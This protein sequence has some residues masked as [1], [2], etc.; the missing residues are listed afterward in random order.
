MFRAVSNVT[1]GVA[2]TDIRLGRLIPVAL[3]IVLLVAGMAPAQEGRRSRAAIT[4]GL[5]LMASKRL[6]GARE[7]V[8][9]AEW[10]AALDALESL[11]TDF[12]DALVEI[13]PDRFV[14]VHDV[15]LAIIASM[16]RDGLAIYRGRVDGTV[17]FL[18]RE[19]RRRD[20]P[21]A[22]SQLLRKYHPSSYGDDALEWLAEDAWT[23]GE[24]DQARMYWTQLVP[25]NHSAPPPQPLVLRFPD[26]SQPLPS[27]LARLVLCSLLQRDFAAAESELTAFRELYPDAEGALAGRD[28]RLCEILEGVLF[29]AR[30]WPDHVTEIGCKTFACRPDRNSV[31][32]P[33]PV[34]LQPLWQTSL[35]RSQLRLIDVGRP[36]SISQL[37][38]ETFPV[39]DNG[40]VLIQDDSGIRALNLSDGRPAWPTGRPDDR[41]QVYQATDNSSVEL[42]VLGIP[43]YSGTVSAGRFFA[44]IGAPVSAVASGSLR[45]IDD[46]LISL[47]LESGEGRLDWEVGTEDL[48][49]QEGWR[50]TGAPLA[51]DERLYVTIRRTAV[52]V[53]LA[54]A[55]IDA[56]TG[57]LLWQQPVAIDL[58]TPPDAY[59][60]IEHEL[61]S[62]GAGAVYFATQAGLL[63]SLN[64]DSGQMNWVATYPSYP[65]SPAEL[66]HP[67]HAGLLPPVFDRGT[68][69]LAPRDASHVMA[70][71]AAT[72][73]L[74]WRTPKPG[75]INALLG[76]A[77]N[78]LV[79]GGDRLWRISADSG[80]V[81]A[82]FGYDDPAGFGFGRGAIAGRSIFWTTREELFEV[83]IASGAALR[84]IPLELLRQST[85]GNLVI[86]DG[87]LLI[88]EPGRLS[89][90]STR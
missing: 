28:G 52:Q 16:P 54:I 6:E 72:G 76:I 38:L 34:A 1:H 90:F 75:R 64:A 51:V 8:T 78:V 14:N 48:L 86:A 79:A 44:R 83:E 4:P 18:Y 49:D 62:F 67:A 36:P 85:G 43:R 32:Q 47:N 5:S 60:R 50:F 65:L 35:A 31:A 82:P 30:T 57:Q 69:Y 80:R 74:L 39:V 84:R 37:T 26:A 56:K 25:V 9:L 45:R 46:R 73:V 41:G 27:I 19:A 23:R 81:H 15:C 53:E 88:A 77:D 71:D 3:S 58:E 59:H 42:P 2:G 70:Y 20:D 55:C 22:M 21:E 87:H 7:F 68:L 33:L 61:L 29:E 12:G 40:I 89:V 63:V 17:E 66:S 13:E 24:L 11:S 10:E